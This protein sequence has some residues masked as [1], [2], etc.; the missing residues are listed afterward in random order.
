MKLSRLVL[1]TGNA[2]KVREM[3]ALL[4]DAG[5]EVVAQSEFAVPEVPETGLSF[6][7][8]ALI[9]A[10]NAARHAGLPA[11][12][13]DSGLCVDAL[14]GAPGIYSARYSG[15]GDDAAN[16]QKLLAELAGVAAGERTARFHCALAMV[17]HGDDPLPLICEASWHGQIL[18]APRGSGGFGYDPLF[19]PDGQQVTSAE[20]DPATK[21]RL[22]HRGQATQQYLQAI[23]RTA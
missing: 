1:A 22:S 12:A 13:D 3:A 5:I 6:L 4:A 20:L 19:L 14:D 23:T 8:N 21:N 17:L 18:S 11:L 7:E 10:R 16:N 9:K 2:G 15:T